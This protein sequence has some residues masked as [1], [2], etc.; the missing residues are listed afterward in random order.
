METPTA[1]M[2][3]L[4]EIFGAKEAKKLCREVSGKITSEEP[5]VVV[6]LSQVKQ[7]DLAGVEGLLH[8][9]EEIAK[10]DG[11]IQLRGISAEAATTLE[12]T[13]MTALFHTFPALAAH[14]QSYV[15][16]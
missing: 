6:D 7:I 12:W 10:K 1:I 13:R 5:C 9:M 11:A 4:P 16:L 14:T 3:K 15:F 8:C 2:I